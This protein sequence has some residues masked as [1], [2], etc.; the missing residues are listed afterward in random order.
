MDT[1]INTNNKCFNY[2]NTGFVAYVIIL[3]VVVVVVDAA[4][5]IVVVVAPSASLQLSEENK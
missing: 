1:V 2:I 5:A 3:V 4:A